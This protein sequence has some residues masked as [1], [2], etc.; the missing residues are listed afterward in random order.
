MNS[1][2]KAKLWKEFSLYIRLSNSD[3]D[4]YCN[5]IS[6]GERH[7]YKD[8][9]AGHFIS[10]NKGNCYYFSENNVWP[11]CTRCNRFLHGNL[12]EY[13][14][15]LV[16]KLGEQKTEL[17]SKYDLVKYRDADFEILLG[18]YKIENKKLK[19]DKSLT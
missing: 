15:A 18:F 14:R 17:L 4:G 1:K 19:L 16:K 13:R 12:L 5:C 2:L 8:I 9:D 7:Y 11:Q 3:K 6:C 10:K